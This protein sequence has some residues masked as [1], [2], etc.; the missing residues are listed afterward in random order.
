MD[1][2][3]YWIF[4]CS[5][6]SFN[7]FCTVVIVSIWHFYYILYHAPEEYPFGS[8]STA[9]DF[10]SRGGWIKLWWWWKVLCFSTELCSCTFVF[11]WTFLCYLCARAFDP[12]FFQGVRK[13]CIKKWIWK[14]TWLVGCGLTSHS[15]IFQLYSDGTVVQFSKFWPAAWH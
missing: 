12:W 9:S 6:I 11:I 7:S 13:V 1:F 14:S 10:S 4:N 3:W 5:T 2:C 15:A 8:A